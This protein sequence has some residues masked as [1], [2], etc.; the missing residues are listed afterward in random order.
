VE[1]E[2]DTENSRSFQISGAYTSLN[3]DFS[4]TPHEN[5]ETSQFSVG[6][7]MI[8]RLAYIIHSYG[9]LVFKILHQKY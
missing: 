1:C 7:T 3:D 4:R 5:L 9:S 6:R 8:Y 2:H